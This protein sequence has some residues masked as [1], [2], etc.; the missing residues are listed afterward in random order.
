MCIV[1]TWHNVTMLLSAHMQ[2]TPATVC[3]CNP[4]HPVR[5]ENT[6]D[7]VGPKEHTAMSDHV[8]LETNPAYDVCS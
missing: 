3:K 1:L 4:P 7:T 5:R 6:Y 8:A 2:A